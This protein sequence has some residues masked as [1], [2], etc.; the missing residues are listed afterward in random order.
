MG[1]QVDAAQVNRLQAISRKHPLILLPTHKSHLDYL[2][3]GYMCFLR[4]LPLPHVVSGENL[5]IPV[6][7]RILRKGGAFF[8]RRSFYEDPL[9]AAVFH[10][11]C[12]QMLKHNF[13]LE[14]FIG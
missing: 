6:I 11:Y 1:I 4:N 5:N 9:Y 8:I 14:C 12:V 2:L 10:E 13:T 3:V 7:G